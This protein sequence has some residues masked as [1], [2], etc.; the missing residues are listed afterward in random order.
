MKKVMFGFVFVAL[1]AL[2]LAVFGTCEN[3]V[4]GGGSS[5]VMRMEMIFILMI[6]TR[7]G[8]VAMAHKDLV[9]YHVNRD[10]TA[11]P[12][13]EKVIK[14]PE[15][16]ALKQAKKRGRPAKNREKTPQEPTVIET[17][18][19]Q[20]VETSLERIARGMQEKQ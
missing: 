4:S 16:K 17:R 9:A 14:K 15:K 13:R 20:E 6:M 1:V 2:G 8:M 5:G 18:T 11:I 10:S 7:D 3:A 19:K 12:A